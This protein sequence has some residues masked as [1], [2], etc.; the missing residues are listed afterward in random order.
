MA[1]QAPERP[2]ALPSPERL[3]VYS[4]R[5]RYHALRLPLWLGITAVGLVLLHILLLY[6]YFSGRDAGGDERVR[7]WMVSTFDLDSEE[8]FG[9]YFSVVTLLFIG[10]LLWHHA[11]QVKAAGEI[12]AVWWFILAVLFHILSI[13]EVVDGHETFKT[14]YMRWVAE[15]GA[16]EDAWRRPILFGALFLGAAFVPFLWQVRHRFALLAYAGGLIYLCGALG[17]DYWTPRDS[18]ENYNL[19]YGYHLWAG[20]EEGLEML[21]PVVFLHGLLAW[22]AKSPTGTVVQRTEIEP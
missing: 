13:E 4:F 14:Y 6:L 3:S 8:S 12:W 17:V 16:S 5:S 21:G 10:R 15:D 9:T 2:D 1:S 19:E 22:L 7:W 18:W 11:K 20:L